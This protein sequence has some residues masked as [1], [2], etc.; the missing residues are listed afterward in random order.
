MTTT[1]PSLILP[2]EIILII[3]ECLGHDVKS[4]SNLYKVNKSTRQILCSRLYQ[5]VHL[6]SVNG[7]VSLCH[8]LTNSRPD[9]LKNIRSL[10]IGLN[11]SAAYKIQSNLICLLRSA[12]EAMPHLSS[13]S[14][15]ITS[16][17]LDNLVELLDP[18]FQL[19]EF[20]HCG[21][22]SPP[23]ARFL[24]K[25]PSIVK[26]GWHSIFLEEKRDYLFTLLDGGE[27]LLP[28]LTE[29]AGPMPL[30]SALIPRRPITKIQVMYHILSFL[31]FENSI[32]GFLRP[33]GC[34]S[35][36]CITEYRPTWQSF[37]A[38][39]SKL[40]ATCVRNTLKELH[41]IEAFTVRFIV[42]N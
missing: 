36:V 27:K 15:V 25:Q 16:G 20:V 22:L 35:S 32:A 24:E 26:L 6:R 40:E 37:T 18:P 28:V 17:A 2:P 23:L 19:T 30:L 5:S 13:L 41:I 8:I 34:L 10:Q 29:L 33:M 12:L 14:L 39:I 7:I 1:I 11:H 3:A 21:E 38:L 9:E 31:R 42:D 4:I